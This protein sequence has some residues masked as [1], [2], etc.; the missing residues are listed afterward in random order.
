MQWIQ[1][2]LRGSSAGKNNDSAEPASQVNAVTTQR[3]SS[4][5]NAVIDTVS[6]DEDAGDF[7][8]VLTNVCR[9]SRE[10]AS[11]SETE[12]APEENC[13]EDRCSHQQSLIESCDGAATSRAHARLLE[14]C[15][16]GDY[17]H[18]FDDLR[19]ASQANKRNDFNRQKY[20]NYKY[21][22]PGDLGVTK[23]G[24]INNSKMV[25]KISPERQQKAT[26][27][28][29]LYRLAQLPPR[30]PQNHHRH[31]DK[32]YGILSQRIDVRREHRKHGKAIMDDLLDDC[33]D[34]LGSGDTP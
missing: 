24:S 27:K 11:L 21:V 22:K 1:N 16:R 17:N 15:G 18:S 26:T 6:D 4:V 7:V 12:S 8:I 2:W 19:S 13:C 33:D 32:V 5:E 23:H 3:H 30:P 31:I 9:Q 14:S 25:G 20:Y 10:S 28:T 29:E 34:A